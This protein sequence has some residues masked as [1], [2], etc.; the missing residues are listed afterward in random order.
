MDNAASD[1]FVH[2][3]QDDPATSW[4]KV[5]APVLVLQGDKDSQVAA[6]ESVAAI[7]EALKDDPKPVESKIFPG[8]N[9]RFQ[10]AKTGATDEYEKIDESINPQVLSEIGQW[11]GREQ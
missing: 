4:R 1:S 5:S 8:L 10:T 11:L 3:L 7:L 9:H 2:F 6:K